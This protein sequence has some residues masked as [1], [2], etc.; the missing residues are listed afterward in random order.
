MNRSL[1]LTFASSLTQLTEL[2]SSFDTGVLRI[3]YAG[4]NQNKSNIS[5][6]AFENAIASMHGI[7]VVCNYDRD[8]D[9]LGGHDMEVVRDQDGG[10]RL[11]NMTTP[12]GFVPESAEV[13]WDTV[14]E[15]D[16]SAHDYLTTEV[17]LWKRQEAYRKIKSDGIVAQ[18]MEIT[19]K[20]GEQKD[21]I[22]YI[23]DFEFTAFALI[24][25]TPCFQSASLEMFS[26]EEFKSL[27]SEMMQEVKE[28]FNQVKPSAEEDDIHPQKYQTEGG[29]RVLDEKMNLAAEYGI[30]VE[31]LDF[32]LEDFTIEELKEKFEAMTAAE[33]EDQKDN[34]ALNSNV[35]EELCRVLDGVMARHEWGE[36]PRY[37]YVDYD[38]DAQEVYC[39]DRE[40]GW[41][42]Y[43]FSYTMNGDAAIIDFENGKRK[44]YVIADFEG[45]EQQASPF[46]GVYELVEQYSAGVTELEQKYQ[47]ASESM[48][49]MTQ[50]LEQL[51][52][53]KH[54]TEARAEAER[55]A[56]IFAQFE[57]LAGVE[58]FEDLRHSAENID[59]EA[60]EE[61][62]FAIRGRNTDV[63]AKFSAQNNERK[64]VKI[65]VGKTDGQTE[66]YGGLFIEYG[67]GS[68]N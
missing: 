4:E 19:V 60:L 6:D 9:S 31:E 43:G 41:M 12:V 18:S 50:E 25:V 2:N 42:L 10:L 23:Y 58:A 51:R 53:F 45:E 24:G 1:N 40:N 65:Q 26:R 33:P 36:Y 63:A 5:K 14:Y 13:W 8:T 61:K 39:W 57:D 66:P 49:A 38:A 52:E 15:E 64:T 28:C 54:D 11:V 22:F 56:A 59:V 48:Q 55:R 20:D 17:I 7:P 62:C 30:N 35:E 32:S 16:G 67:I 47:S 21:D 44:K 37:C 27:F 34:F 46:A 29:E 68:G 3:A